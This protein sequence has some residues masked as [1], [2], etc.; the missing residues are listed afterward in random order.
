MFETQ[1]RIVRVAARHMG[2]S[3][4]LEI[5][6]RCGYAS[7]VTLS[8]LKNLEKEGKVQARGRKW[9]E[10]PDAEPCALVAPPQSSRTDLDS[11]VVHETP[12]LPLGCVV[13]LAFFVL[14]ILSLAVWMNQ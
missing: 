4:T 9:V 3:S 1:K 8:C 14:T 6:E 5:A 2:E 10:I 12:R 11:E 7:N 13:G